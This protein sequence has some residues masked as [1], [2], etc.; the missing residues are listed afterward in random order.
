MSADHVPIDSIMS[1]LIWFTEDPSKVKFIK[2][3]K[4]T[5]PNSLKE[6]AFNVHYTMF[7]VLYQWN[8][9]GIKVWPESKVIFQWLHKYEHVSNDIKC[10]LS[11]LQKC[12]LVSKYTS[13]TI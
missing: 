12:S 9:M 11:D 6:L 5:L 13:N 10:P 2:L 7:L 3:S 4:Q 1:K 8:C